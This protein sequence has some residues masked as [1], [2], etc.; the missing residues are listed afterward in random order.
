MSSVFS[1]FPSNI[2]DYSLCKTKSD[3]KHKRNNFTIPITCMYKR[4]VLSKVNR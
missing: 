2:T 4:K 1:L 3:F